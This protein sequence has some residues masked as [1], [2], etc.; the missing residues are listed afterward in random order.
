[1]TPTHPG[2]V[3]ARAHAVECRARARQYGVW[4]EIA[5]HLED[6]VLECAHLLVFLFIARG[7]RV[8]GRRVLLLLLAPLPLDADVLQQLRLQ[9][10]DLLPKPYD[11]LI[12]LCRL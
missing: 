10:L 5:H 6:L 7:S 8:T 9:R 3:R 1:L 4:E 2:P 11:L 12:L